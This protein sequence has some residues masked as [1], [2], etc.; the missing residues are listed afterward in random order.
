MKGGMGD[1]TTMMI[2]EM[3]ERGYEPDEIVFCDTGSEFPHTYEFIEYLKGWCA[4]RKWSK[5]VVLK[6]LS[7]EGKP[8][9]LIDTIEAERTLPSA[10]FGIKSCSLR[11][12]KETAEVYLNNHPRSHAAWG[13]PGKGRR[14]DSHTGAVLTL[15]GINADEPER[16]EGWLPEHKWVSAYPLLDWEIGE[17]E[18]A[19]VERVGLYYPG[20]SSCYCCPHLTGAE[21][22]MLKDKYPDKFER[23]ARIEANYRAGR[24]PGDK[25]PKGLC[26]KDTIEDKMRKY[27]KTPGA[28]DP[29]AD[30]KCGECR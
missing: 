1:D 27:L 21:L 17:K 14:L 26:R 5:V 7:A 29:T 16:A 2:A 11:F 25:G 24:K 19:A 3:Y 15:I 18:S 4:N 22:F 10:A 13:V 12:K 28:Y 30:Q 6:K 20:K 9:S 8:L 23:V